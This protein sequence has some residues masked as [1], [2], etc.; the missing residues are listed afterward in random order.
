[1]KIFF[2]G[3]LL[4]DVLQR[5]GAQIVLVVAAQTGG[6][7]VKGKESLV[8]RIVGRVTGNAA[9]LLL[10]GFVRHL[11]SC[12]LLANLDMALNAEIRHL[13]LEQL[14]NRRTVGIVAGGAG[15]GLDRCMDNPRSLQGPVEIRVAFQAL[16][17]DSIFEEILFRCFM[18]GMAFGTGTNGNGTVHELLLERGAI[19]TPQTEACPVLAR[20][21][22][23]PS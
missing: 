2:P 19:M 4:F 7:L 18:G 16:I 14:G 3:K 5:G 9:P 10:E 12:Q 15:A 21:Q 8:L 20:V 11:Y 22:Q 17:L 6:H 13:L 23:K 1:M